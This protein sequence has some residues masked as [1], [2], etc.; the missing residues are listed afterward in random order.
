MG[1]V[2][3]KLFHTSRSGQGNN[4]RPSQPSRNAGIKLISQAFRIGTVEEPLTVEGVQMS[5]NLSK[6]AP[7]YN[8]SRLASLVSDRSLQLILMPTEKCNFRCT[9][10]YED[11]AVGRMS[12][13]VIT[14]VKAMLDRRAPE[15]DDLYLNW[16][17][18]EPL[19]A[20]DIIL[21][22]S[23]HASSLAQAFPNLGYRAGA[24]TNAY[25]LN[26]STLSELAAVGVLDYQISL[27]G[28]RE[29]HDRSRVRA[30]GRGTYDRIWANLLGIRDSTEPVSIVLRIHFDAAT[31]A[32]MEP[33]LEDIRREFLH[34]QR[35]SVYFKPIE[36]LGGPNDG[37][38]LKLPPS[39]EHAA[40]ERLSQSLYRDEFS[41]P[42]EEKEYVCY[43]SKPNSL[44]IRAKGGV[45]KCTVALYDSRNQIGTL[46]PDGTLEGL[47]TERLQI[48][49]R[50]LRTLD[51][52][53]LEC[54]LQGLAAEAGA[55]R[56]TG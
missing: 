9:Y 32:H 27:D 12:D 11:F 50:G 1:R 34:D 48:W 7:L 36:R 51:P 31:I 19:V 4:G 43:A 39:E 42:P 29:I 46:R 5:M 6:A 26:R 49:L 47:N 30:D 53:I 14:G 8:I 55:Q 23:A 13:A 3:F 21:H 2:R 33:L 17:G 41:R 56:T 18:G 25:L 16:F 20:K 22:I 37:A 28:P 10:C 54:P 35:F 40:I 15:L 44:V 52:Q 38:I 45:G 24:T